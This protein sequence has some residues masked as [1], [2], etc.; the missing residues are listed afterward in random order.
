MLSTIFDIV[1]SG[2]KAGANELDSPYVV[3]GGNNFLDLFLK[4]ERVPKRKTHAMNHCFAMAEYYALRNEL[5]LSS[6]W[7]VSA[8]AVC[9][10]ET[11][12]L[13]RLHALWAKQS[14]L[15]GDSWNDLLR[16][17]PEKVEKRS[18]GLTIIRAISKAQFEW[19]QEN[20]ARLLAFAHS[21][22]TDI[23]D[24]LRIQQ[25]AQPFEQ[26]FELK[27]LDAKLEELL[28]PVT[29]A[30]ESCDLRSISL[31]RH[32]VSQALTD[33][34]VV[35]F[36]RPQ[37]PT[38]FLKD[39]MVAIFKAIE[40][41]IDAT[42]SQDFLR[43]ITAT[44]AEVIAAKKQLT[45]FPTC[46]SLGLLL[47][48]FDKVSQLIQDAYESSDA[49]KPT[50]LTIE[51]YDRKYPFHEKGSD[52]RLRFILHNSGPGPAKDIVVMF[53]IF[54]DVIPSEKVVRISELS[55]G[56]QAIDID[57]KLGTVTEDVV[58][59]IQIDWNN[60]DST[61]GETTVE[62]KLRCQNPNVDWDQLVYADPYNSDAIDWESDR[63]F[64]GRAADLRTLQQSFS[65]K[66]VGSFYIY[67][68]K[69]VG[70]TSLAIEAVSRAQ[71]NI[72][73]F[74]YVY[75]EGGDYVRPSGEG[76]LKSLGRQIVTRLKRCSRQIER[77]P[78]P[79]FTD[80]I[81]ELN[82]Y[83]EEVLQVLP[84]SRFVIVLDEF[85]ELPLD[86][87]KRGPLGDSFFLTLRALSGKSRVGLILIGGEKMNPIIS[88]QGDQ[89]N[90]FNHLRVDYFR[91]EDQ[92]RDF[93][94]LVR[95]P[96]NNEVEFSDT[97]IEV[98][99]SWSAGNPYFTNMICREV[100]KRCCDRR[101]SYVTEREVEE[102]AN[103]ACRN[104]G[105]NSFAHFWEDGVLDT[106]LSTEDVS[107]MRRRI[108][109]SLAA[110][111]RSGLIST[112][113]NFAK[114]YDLRAIPLKSIES[115]LKRFV[116]RGV[117][118]VGNGGEYRCRVTF[119]ERFLEERS[120][121]LISTDFTDQEERRGFEHQ[122]NEA[123]VSASE[124]NKLVDHWGLYRSEKVTDSKVRL[125]LEQFGTKQNQRLMFK[126]LE[127]IRFYSEA[128]VREKLYIAMQHVRRNTVETKKSGE[129]SR[130]DILVSY[131]GGVAKSGTQYA[132]MFCQENSLLKDNAMN[133]QGLGE[134]VA[135]SGTNIQ[136]IVFVEDFIGTG[137]T[138]IEAMRQLNHEIGD[139][140]RQH[141]I[142]L[143]ILSI[144]GFERS[145]A[146]IKN[147]AKQCNLP[148]ELFCCDPLDESD[149]AF[150]ST[151]KVFPHAT[152]R[153]QACALAKEKGDF[154]ERKYPLGHGECQALV[155]F[156]SN[157]PNNTLPILYKETERWIPLFPRT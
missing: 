72:A 35:A 113:E 45:E 21:V 64:I 96:V 20:A 68:Q 103:S 10:Q 2:S 145:L 19:S 83:M 11:E 57:V 77:L 154:L 148:I 100:L 121:D 95:E 40:S 34:L 33:G 93:E 25:A 46:F 62:G 126:L 8:A 54:H 61:S 44:Q 150:S 7:I 66:T 71:E 118:T 153:E 5:P 50:S 138:V 137:G 127:S 13:D 12:F 132:R 92:W 112:S 141:G 135:K 134:R 115:E 144:C 107:V 76:T 91:R 84:T 140:V 109:L 49:I 123:F 24:R 27:R 26:V 67:G 29:A 110:I 53:N 88:A 142:K 73:E 139:A 47:P 130:R 9:D 36:V 147:A 78:E 65:T 63:P 136:A 111:R 104:A 6:D 116:E 89:L 106:G 30:I 43:N 86:L 79:N 48:F 22:C 56:Q 120:A 82:E 101:D 55:V 87:F 42:S 16:R 149:M 119:F 131:L 94:C 28:A 32:T 1:T 52:V 3:K 80:S 99:Y 129:K 146:K 15:E 85:D 155:A 157:C 41:I 81:Q 122:E 4:S 60:M 23:F 59:A 74:K 133:L 38:G 17:L 156:F 143:F 70:K 152:E 97:A 124:I 108:L 18:V 58:Y 102:C 31:R 151:S 37:L 125:W 14:G 117:F 105:A 114:Q 39:K 98:M 51:A 90:R 75:L 69:R 128:M